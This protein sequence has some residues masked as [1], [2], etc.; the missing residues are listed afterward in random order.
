MIN[1]L[2]MSYNC[3]CGSDSCNKNW[4]INRWLTC[5]LCGDSNHED[6]FYDSY[7]IHCDDYSKTKIICRHCMTGHRVCIQCKTLYTND[8][9][10]VVELSTNECYC[11]SCIGDNVFLQSLTWLDE[12]DRNRVLDDVYDIL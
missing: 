7:T 9:R 12:N 11:T 10:S 5:M 6:H 4:C 8:D 2:T 1:I 3:A